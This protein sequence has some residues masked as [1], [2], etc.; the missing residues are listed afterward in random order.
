MGNNKEEI[1]QNKRTAE[2]VEK[3]LKMKKGQS[4]PIL[5]ERVY[6][7]AKKSKNK[8]DAMES[9]ML[10]GKTLRY[11]MVDGQYQLKLDGKEILVEE[12]G[13]FGTS[14]KSYKTSPKNQNMIPDKPVK[15]GE[16][17]KL[18]EEKVM[19]LIFEK[20]K[21]SGMIIDESKTKGTGKLLAVSEKNG[22]TYGK[23]QFTF[24]VP[25]VKIVKGDTILEEGSFSS[26]RVTI[27]TP[28]DGSNKTTTIQ[29]EAKTLIHSKFPNNQGE[30][31]VEVEGQGE[32]IR[33]PV[34]K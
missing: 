13:E 27:D 3:Y 17:W 18:N 15:V 30:V 28:I 25:L 23:L 34:K 9:D 29:T 16:S 19:K 6:Q 20:F 1:I 26:F 14:F 8:S 2:F 32:E 24:E 21:S 10:E 12:L 33:T 31:K 4:N 5:G 22:T 11:E 7:E